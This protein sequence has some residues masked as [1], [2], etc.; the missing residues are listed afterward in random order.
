M[1]VV[2]N[3]FKICCNC[4]TKSEVKFYSQNVRFDNDGAFLSCLHGATQ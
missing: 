2:K 1:Y 4:T 3:K